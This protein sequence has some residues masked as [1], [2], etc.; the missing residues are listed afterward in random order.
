LSTLALQIKPSHS[1]FLFEKLKELDLNNFCK[2][3][4]NMLK[5]LNK[6]VCKGPMSDTEAH[7]ANYGREK[8]GGPKVSKEFEG[9]L[10]MRRIH[11]DHFAIGDDVGRPRSHSLGD[12]NK[13]SEPQHRN[14]KRQNSPVLGA[15]RGSDLDI[16]GIGSLQIPDPK[17]LKKQLNKDLIEPKDIEMEVEQPPKVEDDKQST[18]EEDKDGKKRKPN[19]VLPQ[20]VK[21]K[22]ALQGIDK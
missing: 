4:L 20:S 5:H 17:E 13:E 19:E 21:I 18:D 9:M 22:P 8:S 6:N 3:T 2:Y 15:R 16:K 14:K 10:E 1:Q 12:K 11:A 7:E